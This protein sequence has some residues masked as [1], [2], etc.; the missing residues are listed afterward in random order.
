[1]TAKTKRFLSACIA[2]LMAF[3]AMNMAFVQ[4][5]AAEECTHSKVWKIDYEATEDHD[6]QMSFYCTKCNEVFESKKFTRHAHTE[7]YKKVMIAP[8]CETEGMGGIVCATCNAVYETYAIDAL[9]HTGISETVHVGGNNEI[10]ILIDESGSMSSSDPNGIRKDAAKKLSNAMGTADKAA[11]VAFDSSARLLTGFTSDKS[12]IDNAIDQAGENGGTDMY[13]GLSVCFD[14]FNGTSSANR[15]IVLLT[16]GDS[17]GSFDYETAAKD[18]GVKIYTVGLGEDVNEEELQDIA[19]RTGGKYY[20]ADIAE[21]LL[22]IYDD[23]AD[24]VVNSDGNWVV[25]LA[26]SC[27]TTGQRT[28]YCSRCG[29]V[30]ATEEIPALGHTDTTSETP[31]GGSNEIVFLIDESGSMSWSDPDG[32]RKDAAKKLSDAMSADD[33]AAVVAFDHSTRLLTGFTSDKTVINNAIDQAGENGGTDMYN[34]LSV[35]FDLFSGTSS[36]NRVI[37]LLTDGD[38]EYSSFDYETAAK[39]KNVKI[40]TV[41]L[42]AGVNEQDLRAIADLTGG[43]YYF[44][45]IAE[46]LLEIYEG[47]AEVVVNSGGTWITTIVPTCSTEGEKVC[48]CD[49]CGEAI[50]SKPIPASSHQYDVCV[51][52]NT[53]SHTGTCVNCGKTASSL[54]CWSEWSFNGDNT[55]FSNGT[56]TRICLDCNAKETVKAKHTSIFGRIFYPVYAFFLRLFNRIPIRSVNDAAQAMG[57]IY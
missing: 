29:M 25:T 12:V 36:A 32:I 55:F 27:R 46:D 30:I 41:G 38:S 4:A 37:V 48:L 6:G 50:A 1:M 28:C 26:P 18:K 17:Y 2:L 51:Y 56:K 5:N 24:V 10:V 42:G 22:E 14:L 8:Y 45:D 49:R 31:I 3:T 11:V 13:N 39:N 35:C 15:V 7:G 9:G 57:F 43:K 40:Y 21:D 53:E 20:F 23:L 19:N 16:D 47:L 33:K 52:T 54:H 34:G 44:A